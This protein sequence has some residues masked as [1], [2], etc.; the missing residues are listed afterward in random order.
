MEALEAY[1]MAGHKEARREA[2][3]KAKKAHT[4][5]KNYLSKLENDT[6]KNSQ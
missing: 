3:V 2:S 4:Q 6:L 1:L 5:L